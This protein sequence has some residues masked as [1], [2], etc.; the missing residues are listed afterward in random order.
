MLYQPED[1][2]SFLPPLGLETYTLFLSSQ[3]SKT[4]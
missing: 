4:R 3:A 2:L 1:L